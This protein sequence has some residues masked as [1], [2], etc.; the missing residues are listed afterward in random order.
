MKI[1]NKKFSKI[2]LILVFAL[3][4]VLVAPAA[5]AKTTAATP[6][7]SISN[8]IKKSDTAITQRIDSLNTLITRVNSA[9]KLSDTEKSTLSSSLQNEIG[10]LTALM[11]K[12]DA[13]TDAATL[14]TDMLSITKSYRIYLLVLP[15][16]S[17]AAASDRILTIVDL[18]N[19]VVTK[20]NAR[21]SQL[22][23]AQNTTSIQT[24][25]SDIAAKLSDA[26]TQAN[27]AVSETAPLIPDQGNT[28][29]QAGNTAMLKDARTKIKTAASDLA[30]ARKDFMTV[31]QALKKAASA[32]TAPPSTT[33]Q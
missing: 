30:A 16:A 10:Q 25:M 7:A 4:V 3:A 9:Q 29:T 31:T 23:P 27:T 2:A 18:M 17:I 6:S 8:M 33:P 11:A 20:L 14:K 28:T 19:G 12:I 26:T 13:D 15:Q 5:F 24:A 21:I 22:T 32:T 1:K